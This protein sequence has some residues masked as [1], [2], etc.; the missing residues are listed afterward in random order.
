MHLSILYDSK[1]NHLSKDHTLKMWLRIWVILPIVFYL[2]AVS[3]FTTNA[4]NKIN[5]I[6]IN[7]IKFLSRVEKNKTWSLE[8]AT[9]FLGYRQKGK[10]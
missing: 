6:L 5:K 3:D 10:L 8:E 4:Y 2:S 1:N 7:N 9:I